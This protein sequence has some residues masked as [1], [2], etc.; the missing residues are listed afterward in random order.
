MDWH[1]DV[2]NVMWMQGKDL[3]AL[4]ALSPQPTAKS[5]AVI[6]GKKNKPH[7]IFKA[8]NDLL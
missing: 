7:C 6:S 1:F 3:H 5:P 2:K 8:R 4:G